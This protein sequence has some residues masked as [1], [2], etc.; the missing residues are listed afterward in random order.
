MS[1]LFPLILALS[2]WWLGAQCGCPT[3]GINEVYADG[4][5]FVGAIAES[6]ERSGGVYFAADGSFTVEFD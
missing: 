1:A 4:S 6:D 3:E 5:R 2:Q